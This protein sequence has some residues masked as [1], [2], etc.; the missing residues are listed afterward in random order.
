[1]KEIKILVLA[2][3]GCGKTTIA[4][5]ITNILRCTGISVDL[6]DDEARLPIA[7]TAEQFAKMVCNNDCHVTVETKQI[8]RGDSTR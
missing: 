2:E 7:K 3:A 6:I 5:Q 1:M 8:A 4:N